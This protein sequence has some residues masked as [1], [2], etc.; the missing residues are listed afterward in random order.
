MPLVTSPQPHRKD[1]KKSTQCKVD[2][3]LDGTVNPQV[4]SERKEMSTATVQCVKDLEEGIRSRTEKPSLGVLCKLRLVFWGCKCMLKTQEVSQVFSVSF[5]AAP[6]PR[7]CIWNSWPHFLPCVQKSSMVP[8]RIIPP[9]SAKANEVSL[10]EQH[11]LKMATPPQTMCL[12]V[13]KN[14]HNLT[15]FE[16]TYFNEKILFRLGHNLM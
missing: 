7:V 10:F 4:I 1:G 8:P 5:S 3:F 9:T 2:R 11:D 16:F 13:F 6:V 12:Q 14:T 15:K